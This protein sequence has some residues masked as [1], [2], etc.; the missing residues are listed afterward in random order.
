MFDVDEFSKYKNSQKNLQLYR[1]CIILNARCYTSP[2][3]S[4]WL[5]ILFLELLITQSLQVA[6]L[7]AQFPESLSC[8]HPRAYL[9]R[10][11]FRSF[12]FHSTPLYVSFSLSISFLACLRS[13]KMRSC[14]PTTPSRRTA[15]VDLVASPPPLSFSLFPCR[16]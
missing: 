9:S 14:P 11:T 5:L 2:D 6:Y 13:T 4:S 16:R 15:C 1:N 12:L 7:S 3:K 10:P 8:H